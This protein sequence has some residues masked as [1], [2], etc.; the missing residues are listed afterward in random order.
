[1]PGVYP[2]RAKGTPLAGRPDNRYYA[3]YALHTAIGEGKGPRRSRFTLGYAGWAPGQLEA[4]MEA[5]YWIAVR[6]DDAIRFDD[7][8]GTKWD[9]WMAKRRISL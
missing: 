1:M 2:R 6:S 9:R 4:E 8:Y 5:G 7:G 3:G